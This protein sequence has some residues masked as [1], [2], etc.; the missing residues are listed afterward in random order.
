MT[1]IWAW[2]LT[3]S[4]CIWETKAVGLLQPCLTKE[5]QQLTI[6]KI[7]TKSQ[8][9]QVNNLLFVT[10]RTSLTQFLN[11]LHLSSHSPQQP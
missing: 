9:S 3:S 1:D 11:T 7:L 2:W 10:I 4:F 6:T 5:R 8:R